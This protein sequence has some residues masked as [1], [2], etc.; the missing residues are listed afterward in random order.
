VRQTTP[1]L[2]FDV[3]TGRA[4]TTHADFS[5]ITPA[6]PAKP[7]ETIVSFLTGLGDVSPPLP[8]GTA[9]PQ[10]PLS[11][12]TSTT[13]V[14][15]GGKTASTYYVGLAPDFI[16]LYQINVTVPSDAPSGDLSF[17]LGTPNAFS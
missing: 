14:L 2:F 15:I 17:E 5:P 10:D 13:V 7:G 4:I 9:A 3:T 1:G 8:A 11:K 16:G 6:N 12:V